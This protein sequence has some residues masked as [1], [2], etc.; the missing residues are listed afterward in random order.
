MARGRETYNR[1]VLH[2]DAA[3]HCAKTITTA[4]EA[5]AVESRIEWLYV[6]A[7]AR[8]PLEQEKQAAVQ[9][10]KSQASARTVEL[11]DSTLWADFDHALV[12]T[13]EF[14]FLR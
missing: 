4:S 3:S 7:F 1:V 5:D 14:I 6:S 9:F 8:R 2:M 13:K 10:L 11:N 12:N